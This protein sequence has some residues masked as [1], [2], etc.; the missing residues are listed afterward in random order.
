MGLR[1]HRALVLQS[2]V[3]VEVATMLTGVGDLA[4]CGN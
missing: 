3:D 2:W 1:L 4:S